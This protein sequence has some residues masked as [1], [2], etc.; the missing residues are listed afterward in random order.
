MHSCSTEE[1]F[2]SFVPTHLFISASPN[3]RIVHYCSLSPAVTYEDD[4]HALLLNMV[5][6]FPA[7]I[8]TM[9]LGFLQ[10]REERV[11]KSKSDHPLGERECNNWG[12]LGQM[13]TYIGVVVRGG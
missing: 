12:Q 10:G 13:T 7:F 3:I 2:L 9:I 5:D 4:S 6:K 8:T 11:L 1:L